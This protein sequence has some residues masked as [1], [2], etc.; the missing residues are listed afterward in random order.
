GAGRF[1]IPE[2][3]MAGHRVSVNDARRN[4]GPSGGVLNIE[5]HRSAPNRGPDSPK[6]CNI[7]VLS[8]RSSNASI[9]FQLTRL[10]FVRLAPNRDINTPHKPQISLGAMHRPS[11]SI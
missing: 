11:E 7:A 8:S 1:D 4:F 6:N 3:A 5:C 2:T 10:I 9:E